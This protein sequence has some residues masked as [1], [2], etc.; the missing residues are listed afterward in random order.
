MSKELEKD[1]QEVTKYLNLDSP[2]GNFKRM[3]EPEYNLRRCAFEQASK[4]YAAAEYVLNKAYAIMLWRK[5][6]LDAFVEGREFKKDDVSR[7][8]EAIA[9]FEEELRSG[10]YSYDN[11][12][13]DMLNGEN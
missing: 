6:V 12:N 4:R 13:F 10:S 2:L 11:F 8:E 1:I 7:I 5:A 9:S 3:D